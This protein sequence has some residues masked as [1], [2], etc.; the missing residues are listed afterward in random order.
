MPTN[1][2][3]CEEFCDYFEK[4]SFTSEPGPN[5]AQFDSYLADFSCLEMTESASCKGYISKR[6]QEKVE[7][8]ERQRV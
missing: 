6:N 4:L 2:G 1:E 3:I 8:R 7:G 5:S